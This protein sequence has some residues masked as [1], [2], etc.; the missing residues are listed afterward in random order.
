M[1][2]AGDWAQPRR[3]TPVGKARGLHLTGSPGSFSA[4]GSGTQVRS[5]AWSTTVCVFA[6]AQS[7]SRVRLFATLW[8]IYSPP[9]SSVHGI[10]QPRILEW[11][12]VSS[13]RGSPQPRDQTRIS[14]VSCTSRRVLYRRAPEKPRACPSPRGACPVLGRGRSRQLT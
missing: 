12:A 2:W 7:F 6:C 13:S 5:V 3:L 1:I 4:R 8:T 11:V 9:G 10:C 14:C